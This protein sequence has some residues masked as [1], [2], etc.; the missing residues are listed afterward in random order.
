MRG[1][2]FRV[3][4]VIISIAGRVLTSSENAYWWGHF[5]NSIFTIRVDSQ[6]RTHG[7]VSL[8]RPEGEHVI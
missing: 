8:P 1:A 3:G 7:E 5:V 4:C 2:L 6:P